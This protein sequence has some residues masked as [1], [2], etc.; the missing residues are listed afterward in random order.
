MKIASSP[1]PTSGY[2][3]RGY[4]RRG[5]SQKSCMSTARYHVWSKHCNKLKLLKLWSKMNLVYKIFYQHI[6]IRLMNSLQGNM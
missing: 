1:L 6:S 3:A 4:S 5:D 2:F